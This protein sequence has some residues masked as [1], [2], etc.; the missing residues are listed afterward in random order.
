MLLWK[1]P[2]FSSWVNPLFLWPFSIAFCMFTRG[3][4]LKRCSNRSGSRL[5]EELVIS[6][7]NKADFIQAEPAEPAQRA[8]RRHISM[9]PMGK[10]TD[11]DWLV[12][13]NIF[14]FPI[15]WECHHPNWLSYFS[16]GL[17]PPTRWVYWGDSQNLVDQ[18]LKWFVFY[19]PVWLASECR[20][21]L[22]IR[23]K[24]LGLCL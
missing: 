21:W 17:K 9:A 8:R 24:C 12:V 2:P 11:R 14:Y 16:D 6:Q 7:A 19:K 22:S 1:D 5:P 4:I 23:P 20:F 10:E 18:P 13:W 15:Y 3:Y